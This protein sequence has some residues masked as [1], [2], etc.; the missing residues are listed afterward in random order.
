MSDTKQQENTT[1]SH[2]IKYLT[3]HNNKTTRNPDKN[4]E[5]QH[6]TAQLN[7]TIYLNKLTPSSHCKKTGSI[8]SVPN[9]L[10][11][12]FRVHLKPNLNTCEGDIGK[13][14]GAI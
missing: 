5:H 14:N 11:I 6:H 9:K 10:E 1:D 4:K 3:L 12:F 2:A 7:L 8:P 13:T